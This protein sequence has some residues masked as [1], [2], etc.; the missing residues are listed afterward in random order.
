MLAAEFF[1]KTYRNDDHR[2]IVTPSESKSAKSSR[3]SSSNNNK[4]N[5][6]RDG[7]KEFAVLVSEAYRQECSTNH[8]VCTSD[9]ADKKSPTTVARHLSDRNSRNNPRA[10]HKTSTA[11]T[12]NQTKDRSAE[13]TKKTNI[14]QSQYQERQFQEK[15][16][17]PEYKTPVKDH[18][19][20]TN[21]HYCSSTETSPIGVVDEWV[22]IRGALSKEKK[23][24]KSTVIPPTTIE[25]PVAG[26]LDIRD[27]VLIQERC[28]QEKILN[29]ELKQKVFDLQNQIS[30]L[31]KGKSSKINHYEDNSSNNDDDDSSNDGPNVSKDCSGI[32]EELL[33]P[34][35]SS[36]S[37]P[38]VETLNPKKV[39]KQQSSNSKRN[40]KAQLEESK[41]VIQMLFKD[42]KISKQNESDLATKLK[43]ANVALH[44]EKQRSRE[45]TRIAMKSADDVRAS[46]VSKLQYDHRKSSSRSSDNEEVE[47][48]KQELARARE[49]CHRW[50]RKEQLARRS[51]EIRSK[52]LYQQDKENR[53]PTALRRQQ[54][55]ESRK[56]T[57]NE[58]ITGR[59]SPV[60]TSKQEKA[61]PKPPQLMEDKPEMLSG[62]KNKNESRPTSSLSQC[63]T[64]SQQMNS[65]PLEIAQKKREPRPT[66]IIISI[67]NYQYHYYHCIITMADDRKRT[68]TLA[69][70]TTTTTASTGSR[71]GRMSS[72][73]LSSTRFEPFPIILELSSTVLRVGFAGEKS[74]PKHV[75]RIDGTIF[76]TES[77]KEKED[78]DESSSSTTTTTTTTTTTQTKKTKTKTESE[79]YMVLSPLIEQVYDRLMCKSSTRRVVCLYSNQRYAPLEFRRALKQHLWN[80][81]VPAVVELD[82][83]EVLPIAQGWKRGLAVNITREEAYC[84]CLA[85]GYTLPFTYQ[86]VPSGGYKHWLRLSQTTNGVTEYV[87]PSTSTSTSTSSTTSSTTDDNDDPSISALV[88]AILACLQKCPVD[89]R[90]NVVSNVVFCGDGVLLLPD[91]PR[92]VM[93]RVRDILQDADNNNNNDNN[94][95]NN[96]NNNGDE[97]RNDKDALPSIP[98]TSFGSIPLNVA[99]LQPL[100]SSVGLTSCEPYRPD[101]IC[102][103]GASLWAAVWNKYNDEETP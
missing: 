80:R 39:T 88:V 30:V 55:L 2:S 74:Q 31:Q 66:T 75:I 33:T 72:F 52:T 87:L 50:K 34:I 90:M 20:R 24:K 83:L 32:L 44:K 14:Q 86:M 25:V 4:N 93:K 17:P 99:N 22:S 19:D 79:W 97:T 100:A 51:A 103:V 60:D 23:K 91:L 85:D 62:V 10:N 94:D 98:N 9:A 46:L 56:L 40:F 26:L 73:S 7:L 77:Q 36:P 16:S 53:K 49:E 92:R 5:S 82:P 18:R 101:W 6:N 67:Q 12:Q 43:A 48:L 84:V 13:A 96:N 58:A 81:G 57:K 95:N 38:A 15:K 37:P 64:I 45:N 11:P 61:T 69:S 28:E 35:S 29:R 102:W 68:T 47:L 71:I 42:L 78:V 65:N 63:H 76:D 89:L 70:T 41:Q 27:Q 8:H 21:D 1:E 3:R 59:R 54:V